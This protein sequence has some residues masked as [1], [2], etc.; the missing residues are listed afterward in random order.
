[1]I[2]LTYERDDLTFTL[3]R[4]DL[5]GDGD[6]VAWLFG[7]VIRIAGQG[8]MDLIV[9]GIISNLED[10]L[11]VGISPAIDEAIDGMV[12]AAHRLETAWQEWDDRL[13]DLAA[14][15]EVGAGAAEG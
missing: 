6:D 3:I 10:H 7:E 5:P 1:M 2:S 11:A 8:R 13:S 4:R 9:A 12:S 15:P 14:G